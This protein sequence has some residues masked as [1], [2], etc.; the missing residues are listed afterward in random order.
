MKKEKPA[1]VLLP[2]CSWFVNRWTVIFRLLGCE[3]ARM[4][5]DRAFFFS[6]CH[7]YYSRKIKKKRKKHRS[8]ATAF[9][10]RPGLLTLCS[11]SAFRVL[12][13]GRRLSWAVPAT[14]LM[15]LLLRQ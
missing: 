4:C 6:R 8:D 10:M 14:Q 15:H 13:D 5:Q 3:L 1:A 12:E 2:M 9:L 11:T 7:C